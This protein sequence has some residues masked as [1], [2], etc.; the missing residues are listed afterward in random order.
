IELLQQGGAQLFIR[1]PTYDLGAANAAAVLEIEP[2]PGK[3]AAAPLFALAPG[4]AGAEAA[5]HRISESS[6]TLTLLPETAQRLNELFAKPLGKGD[7]FAPGDPFA[8]LS[9][10]AQ[11]Q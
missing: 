5:A 6:A 3:L 10:T 7:V 11:A 1:E 9:F 8:S 4:T 2:S